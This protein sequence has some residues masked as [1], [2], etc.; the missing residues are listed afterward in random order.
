MSYYIWPNRDVFTEGGRAALATEVF[1][2]LYDLKKG[3]GLPHGKRLAAHLC[4][5]S[6]VSNVRWEQY[7]A[8]TKTEV[9]GPH[10]VRF[11]MVEHLTHRTH[12]T[13]VRSCMHALCACSTRMQ[14]TNKTHARSDACMAHAQERKSAHTHT[15]TRPRRLN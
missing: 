1:D 13:R 3:G 2:A 11:R 5:E 14:R 7:C 6:D 10:A 12:C 15:H 8:D 9:Y 4:G